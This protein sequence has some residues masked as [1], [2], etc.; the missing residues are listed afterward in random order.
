MIPQ[1][2]RIAHDPANGAHG[3]CMRAMIASLFELDPA[4]VPHFNAGG[5][6]GDEFTRRLN[7]WLRPRNMAYLSFP[8]LNADWLRI[9]GIEGLHHEASGQTERGT[10][11]A[12]AAV[13]TVV[14][15]DPH[16][17]RAGLTQ[18]EFTGVFV[19]LDPSKPVRCGETGAAAGGRLMSS[20]LPSGG[21]G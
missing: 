10:C 21:A 4:T 2:Q 3:D 8:R 17:S 18:V 9:V 16:P 15:H 7:A 20:S 11:H 5:P 1:D 19:V 14:V 12:C 6:D 13:D